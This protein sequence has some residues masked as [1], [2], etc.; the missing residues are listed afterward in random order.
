MKE[1]LA[2]FNVKFALKIGGKTYIPAVSYSIPARLRSTIEDLQEKGKAIIT[3][4]MVVFQ[5]GRPVKQE[6]RDAQKKVFN[7]ES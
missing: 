3:N 6:F 4:E 1:E 5:N 2:Y 7:K